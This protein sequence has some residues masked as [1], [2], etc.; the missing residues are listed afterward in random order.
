MK[1]EIKSLILILIT[2]TLVNAQGPEVTSWVLNTTSATGYNCSG[3][4]PVE[5]G[6][7]SADI[8]SVDY[9]TDNV[10]V[11]TD[12]VPSY[13]VGPWSA[14]PNVPSAQ[15][16]IWKFT[17]SPSE[18]TGVKTATGLGNIGV[19][20]NGVGIYNA[21]DGFYWDDG[22]QI[23]QSGGSGDWN[24]NAYVFEAISFDGCLGHADGSGTYHNHV[25]PT[26][27]Y[28]YTATMV[29][30]PI[31]GYAFDGFP[32]YGAFAYT[33]TDGTGAIKRMASSY[34]LTTNTTR[35]AG[36][37]M[38]VYAAGSFC[39]DYEYT[40]GHGDLDEFN[41]R[42]C[43]TPEYPNGTY[44]Y[45][46]TTEINGDPAYPFVL[47]PSYYGN[48]AKGNTGPQGGSANVPAGATKYVPVTS[49]IETPKANEGNIFVY[50]NPVIDQVLKFE[51]SDLS[52]DLIVQ[53][54]DY[55]GRVL[56]YRI[57]PAGTV[58]SKLELAAPFLNTGYYWVTFI[59]GETNVTKKVLFNDGF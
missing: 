55:Q 5:N 52:N 25:N 30:S 10:Y 19:W 15:N 7:I 45:F 37:T 39:E 3:C 6:T 56:V 48:V 24:R 16:R 18:N 9:D 42:F 57:F 58:G 38:S 20:S 31:I 50:P 13:N 4:S 23:M 26:C 59:S 22:N 44:A 28:D 40:Q 49:S 47:G 36:P 32:I 29:H 34:K 1:I 35:V 54:C 51:V 46:V 12:G 14:N 2:S 41:G 27:L 53:I 33:N 43:I 21:K 11:T 8:A 17:L